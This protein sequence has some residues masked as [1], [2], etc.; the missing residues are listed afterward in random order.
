M[1][2]KSLNIKIGK[3]EIEQILN[4]KSSFAGQRETLVDHVIGY[5]NLG[6]VL[7]ANDVKTGKDLNLGFQDV[8]TWIKRLEDPSVDAARINLAVHTGSLSGLLV[9]EI[10]NQ[11][12]KSRLDEGGEWRSQCV[13]KLGTGL[14]KHFYLL[15]PEFQPLPTNGHFYAEGVTTLLPPSLDPF[16][17]ERWQWQHPPWASA[18]S[19]LPLAILNYLHSL[20]GPAAMGTD[21]GYQPRLPWQE[22]YCLISPFEAVLQAFAHGE[23]S[24][25][26]YYEN[27]FRAALQAGLTDAD[28]LLSLLWHAP[29]GDVRQRPERWHYLQQLVRQVRFLGSSPSPEFLEDTRT[30]GSVQAPSRNS[31]EKVK[32]DR[33]P[34]SRRTS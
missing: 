17:Q 6:W 8:D 29:F 33:Q 1:E 22:L 5:L 32:V 19:P 16:T 28:L 11:E 13:A 9:L 2:P 15:S 18:P 14:E 34:I 12:Q 4:L 26:D 23:A 21:L 27:L 20:P 24:M 10:A 31:R 3:G 25:D 7:L 30:I